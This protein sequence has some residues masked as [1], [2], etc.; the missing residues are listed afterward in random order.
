LRESPE[1]VILNGADRTA[2]AHYDAGGR[3]TLTMLAN[4]FPERLERIRAGYREDDQE[5]LAGLRDVISGMPEIAAV[6]HL[7]HRL[8][9]VPLSRVRPPLR[10]LDPDEARRLDGGL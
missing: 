3:G 5:F 8:V 6:K 9:R 2:A 1:L 4:V 10:D 7:V